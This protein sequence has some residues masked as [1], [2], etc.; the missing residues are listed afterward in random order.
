MARK[1]F[2]GTD[3]EEGGGKRG[4]G[5]RVS[6]PGVGIGSNC[7]TYKRAIAVR[8]EDAGELLG[9]NSTTQDAYPSSARK[10]S[11]KSGYCA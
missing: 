4:E 9:M 5:T 1:L 8:Y 2:F 6:F 10:A 11:R 7:L 3:T